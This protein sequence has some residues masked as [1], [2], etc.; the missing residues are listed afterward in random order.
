MG[1]YEG[2]IAF[3]ENSSFSDYAFL[4]SN[5]EGI[6]PVNISDPCAPVPGSL[7]PLASYLDYSG[8]IR[9]DNDRLYIPNNSTGH[10]YTFSLYDGDV[11][12]AIGLTPGEL[13]YHAALSGAGAAPQTVS[14]VNN[15]AG[16]KPDFS[17]ILKL[18]LAIFAPTG[19]S[20]LLLPYST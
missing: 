4:Y 3:P 5:S 8:D 20:T 14:I 13:T 17:L 7:L 6:V 10:M 12:P 15:G 16:K 1:F 18:S 11:S 9:I 2:K 19:R